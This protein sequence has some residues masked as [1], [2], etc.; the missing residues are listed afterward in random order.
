MKVVPK[1]TVIDRILEDI[2]KLEQQNR[3]ADYVV[4]TPEE[5]DEM[6]KD[7]R[8]WSYTSGPAYT[9]LASAAMQEAY[10]VWDFL[11][12][13]KGKLGDYPSIRVIS[14][15]TFCGIPLLVV[16]AQYHPK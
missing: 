12:T 8:M 7:A 15:A 2:R 10:K 1:V 11:L 4:V 13:G 14:H 9:V 3:K 6:G 5:A 16:P